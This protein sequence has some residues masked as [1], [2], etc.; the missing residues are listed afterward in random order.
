VEK[1]VTID[2]ASKLFYARIN[3][4]DLAGSERVGSGAH[5]GSQATG[6][7]FKV[8]PVAPCDDMHQL[9]STMHELPAQCSWGR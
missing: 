9:I 8:G 3:L 4:I 5:G 6:E 7:H 2:G 1:T